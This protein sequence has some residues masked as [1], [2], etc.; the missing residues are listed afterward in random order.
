M[1]AITMD[2]RVQSQRI[3][4]LLAYSDSVSWLRVFVVCSLAF[5]PAF[6]ITILIELMPLRPP[7]E[8]W[9]ANWVFWV[10][11]FLSSVT[12][13]F[14]IG[15]QTALMIPA[16]GMNLRQVVFV[17]IGTAGGYM[18]QL[19][20]L[21]KYWRFPVPF[22]ILAGNPAWQIS[23]YICLALVVGLKKFREIPEIK[24]QAKAARRLTLIQTTFILVYPAYN[25]IFFRLHGLN[26]LA[27]VLVLP[28]I[29]YCMVRLLAPISKQIPAA[30]SLGLVTIELFDALY[31]FKCMQ[32]A[33][34]ILSGVGLIV[35]DLLQN[36]RHLWN[37]HKRVKRVKRDLTNSATDKTYHEMI[38]ESMGRME[39]RSQSLVDIRRSSGNAVAPLSMANI[40]K[41]SAGST[42]RVAPEDKLDKSVQALLLECEHIVLIEFI[43]CAVPMFYSLYL[44]IL[45]HL[46]NARYY[47]EMH[48]V[49][50]AKLSRTVG[51]IA[52]YAALELF[53]LF[54]MHV[55]LH[56]RFKISALHLLANVL[57][58]D[59]VLL[60]AV[61]T[62][63]VILV[64]QFTVEHQG[65]LQNAQSSC[66]CNI[67]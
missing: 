48:H 56:W 11:S 6:A 53:S 9:Q 32:T 58:R 59:Y 24:K 26:Q 57:E 54:Y 29:K 43:E 62:Q 33:G 8:G 44:V 46:P 40:P 20:V 18:I 38:R 61:F 15:I 55:L 35:V 12:I 7:S 23:R 60:Q 5:A 31:L 63:W 14:G 50:S 64:L 66:V 10:R 37:L 16:A 41:A 19:I 28:V 2:D 30:R 3:R 22:L 36:L 17:S 47:P 13:T 25:A 39:S 67:G 1:A 27:F 52:F 45:F 65:T 4:S 51:N 34:S 49:D 21:A 42:R